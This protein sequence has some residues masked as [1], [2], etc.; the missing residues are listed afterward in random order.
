MSAMKA[1]TRSRNLRAARDVPLSPGSRSL[2]LVTLARNRGVDADE[3][4]EG[5]TADDS[6]FNFDPGCSAR[7]HHLAV[8][9]RARACFPPVSPEH[10]PSPKPL[11]SKL[12]LT[13]AILLPVKR[14]SPKPG[15]KSEDFGGSQMADLAD[16]A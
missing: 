5:R 9:A 11:T 15:S 14:K 4:D 6:M 13:S 1:L 12:V 7:F 16:S 2:W 3:T 8:G 10:T